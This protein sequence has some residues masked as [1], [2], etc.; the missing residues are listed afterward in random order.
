MHGDATAHGLLAGATAPTSFCHSP[1]SG[2]GPVA[3][4]GIMTQPT[5]PAGG[6]VPQPGADHKVADSFAHAVFAESVGV[7]YGHSSAPDI[8]PTSTHDHATTGSGSPY[9]CARSARNAFLWHRVLRSLRMFRHGSVGLIL[10]PAALPLQVVPPDLQRSDA[11]SLRIYK[12]DRQMAALSRDDAAEPNPS[13]FGE[14][15]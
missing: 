7:R 15:A 2:D 5:I 9:N 14:R 13:T 3:R 11:N 8:A 10:R 12:E 6:L 4:W 1:L